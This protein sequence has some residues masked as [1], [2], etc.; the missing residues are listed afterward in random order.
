MNEALSKG[1]LD[2]VTKVRS[3]L[4]QLV[5]V[6]FMKDSNLQITGFPNGLKIVMIKFSLILNKG[7]NEFGWLLHCVKKMFTNCLRAVNL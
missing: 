6:L 5:F 2:D 3:F 4:L 7:T 1:T